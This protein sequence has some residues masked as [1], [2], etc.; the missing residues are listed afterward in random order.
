MLRQILVP[1]DGSELSERALSPAEILARAQGAELMLVRVLEPPVWI[2]DEPQ[3][4]LSPELYQE[5]VDALTAE[6]KQSLESLG[7]A[8][9]RRD[10]QAKWTILEGTPAAGLLDYEH[11]SQPDLVVMAT[12]GRSG[13]ARFALGSV[14]DRLVREGIAPVLLVRSFTAAVGN[15]DSALVPLDGSSVAESALPVVEMLAG[16]PLRT[17]RLLRAVSGS[18]TKEGADE[19]LRDIAERL[20][21]V[22]L[23][24]TVEVPTEEPARAIEE[25]A[26]GVDVVILATH[27]RGGLER[28]RHGSVA[29]EV[30]HHLD[31]PVLLVRAGWP[32]ERFQDV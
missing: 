11:K 32:A 7:A 25:G 5:L 31:V 16:K 15:M 1:Y 26:K 22:G 29:E 18:D 24:T 19:Y 17:V 27:G 8:L 21:V 12:H 6:A 4:Y 20:R 3:G 23:E 9:S 28:L 14:A 10:L 2:G 30:A 13:L